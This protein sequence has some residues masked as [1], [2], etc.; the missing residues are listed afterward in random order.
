MGRNIVFTEKAPHPAGPY[1]QGIQLENDLMFV[2]GQ[3]GVEPETGE[4]AGTVEEQAKQA[5]ENM[6]AVV[7]AGGGTAASVLKTTLFL[8]DME[9]YTAVNEIYAGF[10]AEN[11]P[12]RTCVEVSALP[13]GAL[14]EIECIARV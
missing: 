8:A 3:I 14:I 2:S 12:A 10:F 13:K 6:V 4:L 9:K 5:L 11:P 1:S 7:H